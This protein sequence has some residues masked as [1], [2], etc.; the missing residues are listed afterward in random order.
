MR[1]FKLSLEE[2]TRRLIGINSVSNEV[3]NRE[4]VDFLS[5]YL[6][7]QKFKIFQHKYLS[8]LKDGTEVEKINL[9]A[10]KGTEADNLA[11]CP[12]AFSGHTDTVPFDK[13]DWKHDPL[14]FNLVGKK[15]F[16]RGSCDMKTAIAMYIKASENISL[17][18]LKKPLG[19]IFSADEEIGC[20]GIRMLKKDCPHIFN[21]SNVVIGEPTSFIPINMH[22]GY[23][24]ISIELRGERGG[25]SRNPD[26][27]YNVIEKALPN[28]LECLGRIKKILKNIRNE[29]FLPPYPTM[30]IGVLNTAKDAAKNKIA[31]YLRL[32]LDIRP[33]PNQD[34]VELFDIL[35]VTCKRAVSSI[36]GITAEVKLAK[37]PTI[38]KVSSIDS[39]L[40]LVA[41]KLSNHPAEGV[42]FNTEAPIFEKSNCVIW[43]PGS[44]DQAH[45]P[46]E[47]I[48][49]EWIQNP[50]YINMYESVIKE[51]CC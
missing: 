28:I 24:Y 7:K 49:A 27:G 46:D 3:S 2:L 31:N 35:R 30:N 51:F 17:M 16:G 29:Q 44:I 43:G 50:V 32:D 13:D 25:H 23:M 14:S 38:P 11:M 20:Q 6:E 4:I 33:L 22:K 47:Y 34:S 41:C 10:A 36:K 19:M 5:E 9:L 45:Q 40:V 18:Q 12:L 48:D 42:C 37:R 8:H 21:I 39:K 15:Y 26:E 1:N